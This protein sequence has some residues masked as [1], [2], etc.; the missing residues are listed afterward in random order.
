[1]K[2]H[3]VLLGITGGIAAC[4]APALVRR[5]REAGCEVR[6]A[7]TRAGTS[8]VTP[9]TL[10][11]LS[12]HS[13]YQEEYL[14]PG[15]GGEEE[16]VVVAAW[17]DLLLIAPAT[18]HTLARLSLGL[19]D[20]F[21]TT[22]SLV[23]EGPV[24]IAPA[25]HSAMWRQE[26]V[27]GHVER[28]TRRGVRWI[29]PVEGPL[30][31][32]ESGLGRMAEPEDIVAAVVRGGHGRSWEGYTV[33]VAAG[34]TREPLDPV[35]FL[36]NRSSGRMGFALAAAAASRGAKVTLVAG[37]VS[38]TAPPG[39]ERVDIETAEQMRA[40]V[41]DAAATADLVIM[42][43]AVADFRPRSVAEQKLKKR[44]G[45]PVVE[46]EPT[47]DILSELAR[48]APGAVRVGFAA[49]TTGV[50]AAARDKLVRKEAD[51]I[52]ANDVGRSDIGFGGDFNAVTVFGREREPIR[53]AR[54]PKRQLADHLLD[55][56]AAELERPESEHEAGRP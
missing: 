8:F 7:L 22:L 34:P 15:V 18:A 14:A 48:V 21:L 1:M 44:Q 46:L 49:E 30:A 50:E 42:A 24:A 43:A 17:T 47:I 56:F 11:V 16:H 28:L 3:R 41:T 40:A 33:V 19:A 51:W 10:E 25:M 9:L 31:S 37:P 55:L 23:Y 29:G 2:P 20:D 52:V 27:Q 53:L 5:L 54:Q 38:L 4:K 13:V 35:R 45:V 32:G 6:C 26:T 36:S 12:G 39:V